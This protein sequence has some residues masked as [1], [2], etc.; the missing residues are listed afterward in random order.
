[1]AKLQA[2][3]PAGARQVLQALAPMS[4]RPAGDLRSQLLAAYV[5]VAE[6]QR[7]TASR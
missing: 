5:G 4:G 3:D 2:G 6:R 7:Q 1:M